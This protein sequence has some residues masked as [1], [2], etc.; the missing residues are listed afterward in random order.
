MITRALTMILG[1]IQLLLEIS[2]VENVHSINHG[3]I[4]A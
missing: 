4:M 3:F 1:K 2:H